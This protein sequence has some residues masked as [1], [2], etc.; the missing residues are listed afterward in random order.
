M[1]FDRSLCV[2]LRALAEASA[3]NPDIYEMR[4]SKGG[5]AVLGKVTLHSAM[6]RIQL[7]LRP[8]RP[9]REICFCRVQGRA[10]R[11]EN[12]NP[13]ALAFERIAPRQ[14]A[15]GIRRELGLPRVDRID[16]RLVA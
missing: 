12:R 1:R 15:R 7:S 6:L 9:G 13:W 16:E 4:S 2:Q 8:F 5:P 14:E 3:L 11:E 10:S